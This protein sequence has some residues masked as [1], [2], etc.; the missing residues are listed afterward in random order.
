MKPEP[1]VVGRYQ[2][3]LINNLFLASALTIDTMLALAEGTGKDERGG[4]TP[5]PPASREELTAILAKARAKLETE[6]GGRRAKT[7][8]AGSRRSRYAEQSLR[9]FSLALARHGNTRLRIYAVGSKYVRDDGQV[10][11]PR[12]M[13]PAGGPKNFYIGADSR[14]LFQPQHVSFHGLGSGAFARQSGV[15][16]RVGFFLYGPASGDVEV[17]KT[18]RRRASDA[19]AIVLADGLVDGIQT[20]H[21][22]TAFWTLVV[23]SHLMGTAWVSETA[24]DDHDSAFVFHPFGASVEAWRL[25]LAQRD[26]EKKSPTARHK[27]S[28][29]VLP[30]SDAIAELETRL[31]TILKKWQ[32]IEGEIGEDVLGAA[33]RFYYDEFCPWAADVVRTF[34]LTPFSPD[35]G[36]PPAISRD[37][38]TLNP[39]QNV[40]GTPNTI[41]GGKRVIFWSA[42]HHKPSLCERTEPSYL[43]TVQAWASKWLVYQKEHDPGWRTFHQ[44]LNWVRDAF[45]ELAALA[46]D[47][48][49]AGTPAPVQLAKQESPERSA[50]EAGA[51]LPPESPPA[52][53][54]SSYL[55]L[56]F[57]DA[58][59]TVEREGVAG[60]VD[61][62]R[63]QL[64]WAILKKL[65]ENHDVPLCDDA[66]RA[67]WENH[68]VA[69]RPS[70]GTVHDAVSALRAAIRPL[71]LTIETRRG[72]GRLL[73]HLPAEKT[74]PPKTARRRK[75]NR[76]VR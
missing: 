26:L 68:G 21:D 1:I 24:I 60:S 51:A 13:I 71:G 61:L 30:R 31:S 17:V 37:T 28:A 57:Y 63:S 19:G 3:S 36:D 54:R 64:N 72:L 12:A 70:D 20:V 18:F 69:K 46:N 52:F 53:H 25:I 11:V 48:Y 22:P 65:A 59:R 38:L 29:D 23:F 41:A 27:A 67:V 76:R 49:F 58:R 15:V 42:A 10:A 66:I 34:G 62:S 75:N 2:F 33:E 39:C 6:R 7:P 74:L 45:K 55:G 8:P 32:E 4:N 9:A 40:T 47:D 16:E 50:R 56:L 73:T 43:P 5:S 14:A 35:P 44:G